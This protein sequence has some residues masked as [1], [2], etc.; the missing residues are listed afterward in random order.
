MELPVDLKD[1]IS[2]RLTMDQISTL[3]ARLHVDLMRQAS[4]VCPGGA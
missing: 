4:A 2:Y 1:D 3:T